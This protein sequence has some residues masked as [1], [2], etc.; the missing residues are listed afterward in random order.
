MIDLIEQDFD[1]QY[2][3]FQQQHIDFVNH[4]NT[5]IISVQNQIL[6]LQQQQ[7]EFL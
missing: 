4:T 7:G 2:N 5:Q 1:N 6:Q 3:I